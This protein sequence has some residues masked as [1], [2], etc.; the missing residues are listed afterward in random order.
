MMVVP[1]LAFGISKIGLDY[2]DP[3]TLFGIRAAFGSVQ[4]A[5]LLLAGFVY[6]RIKSKNDTETVMVPEELGV[7]EK[8]KRQAEEQENRRLREE[9]IANG[10]K[11]PPLLTFEDKEEEMTVSEYDTKELRKM[12]QT[13]GISLIIISIMHLKF[14]FVQPLIMQCLLGPMKL[15]QNPLLK[16]YLLGS[17]V[18]RPFPVEEPGAMF[19]SM[20]EPKAEAEAATASVSSSS[21]NKKK[22]TRKAE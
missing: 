6:L 19:K 21:R 1:L 18:Q 13:M 11:C 2:E 5:S 15:L 8:A 7:M 16:V 20:L 9:A 14:N 3:D 22:K 12:L 17:D 10:T 4:L